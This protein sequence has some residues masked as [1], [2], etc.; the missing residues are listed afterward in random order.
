MLQ[1]LHTYKHGTSITSNTLEI[2][3][4]QHGTSNNVFYTSMRGG[5]NTEPVGFL[6]FERGGGRPFE[7]INSEVNDRKNAI[8]GLWPNLL[9]AN[10]PK[11]ILA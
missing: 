10:V 9:R 4:V 6:Y 3:N 5:Q 11:Q 2:A 1:I 8:L 7:N